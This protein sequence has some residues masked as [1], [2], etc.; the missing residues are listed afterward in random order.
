MNE[1]T[2][3][4][5]SQLSTNL[6]LAHYLVDFETR[7]EQAA[8]Q[9][10]ETVLTQS[11]AGLGTYTDPEIRAMVKLEQLKLI[12]DLGLAEILLRGK[13]IKEI[14]EEALWNIHPNRY[15]N[16]QEAARA[17]GISLSEYSNI[18][19]L[20]NVVFP[21]LT[22]TLEMN[23]ALVW[24]EVGKSNLREL[25][26]YLVRVISGE[27]SGSR[28]VEGYIAQLMDDVAASAIA[29]E[30]DISDGEVQEAVVRQLL[31]TGRLTNR[32]VRRRIHDHD[33]QRIP[34]YILEVQGGEVPRKVMV[35]LVDEGQLDLIQR[36]LRGVIETQPR[37]V[38][39]LRQ[40]P[41]SQVL[42][43]AVS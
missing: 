31:T 33:R 22:Q 17:Q 43:D 9:N 35:S 26:P 25:T 21:Y 16:M 32:E 39:D 20:Y 4:V 6:T 34:I 15:T 12:G 41:L 8:R 37:Q 24:E 38:D 1:N 3:Q 28:H 19:D 7:S 29:N 23:L 30:E 36:R 2:L 13:I 14:E 40:T 5:N 27:E 11:G 10:L 18:R 42:N